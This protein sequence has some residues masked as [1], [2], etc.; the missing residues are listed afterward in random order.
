MNRRNFKIGLKF[1]GGTALARYVRCTDNED[2][3]V[4]LSK[5]DVAEIGRQS[6]QPGG[7][8]WGDIWMSGDF[9]PVLYSDAAH[10]RYGL[11]MPDRS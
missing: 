3:L 6:L 8:T 2:A 1:V 10:A 4:R 9:S 11:P 5:R 7:I